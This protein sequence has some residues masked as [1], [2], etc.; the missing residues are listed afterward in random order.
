MARSQPYSKRKL[1]KFKKIAVF[2]PFAAFDAPND[3]EKK[4]LGKT[5][6]FAKTF[7]LRIDF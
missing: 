5:H 2:L 4:G 3:V 7:F 1:R 6:S